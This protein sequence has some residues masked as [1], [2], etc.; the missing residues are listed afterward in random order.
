MIKNKTLPVRKLLVGL[1]ASQK[2]K[3]S[4]NNN[5]NMNKLAYNDI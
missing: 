4:N 3:Y 5:N 1:E 2:K